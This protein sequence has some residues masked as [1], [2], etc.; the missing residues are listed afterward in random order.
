MRHICHFGKSSQRSTACYVSS[1]A[2]HVPMANVRDVTSSMLLQFVKLSQQIKALSLFSAAQHLEVTLSGPRFVFSRVPR[3][4]AYVER[5]A[6]AKALLFVD[7]S[8]QNYSAARAEDWAP[9]LVI[10]FMT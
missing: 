3:A 8:Q 1:A 6:S 5:P 2:Y 7:S 4:R 9:N 10:F